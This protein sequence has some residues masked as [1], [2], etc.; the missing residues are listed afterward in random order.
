M[1]NFGPLRSA[2]AFLALS[3]L[4]VLAVP[5]AASASAV[6]YTFKTTTTVP[7]ETSS[8][9]FEVPA[10]IT[11]TGT[12]TITSLLSESDTGSFWTSFHCGPISGVVLVNPTSGTPDL[13]E[14]ASSCIAQFPFTAP[15][16]TFGTFVA[17]DGIATLTISQ[18]PEPAT[19]LLFGSGWLLFGI[20]VGRKQRAARII[21]LI[22]VA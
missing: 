1:S 14:D 7:T 9:S 21:G 15:I 16:D 22:D 19:V 5:Q 8:F 2:V 12:T 3:I 4:A 10:I 20:I 11:G 17:I 18:T 13:F 6:L